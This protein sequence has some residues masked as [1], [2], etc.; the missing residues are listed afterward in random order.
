MFCAL[1]DKEVY[2]DGR[3]GIEI[4]VNQMSNI[5]AIGCNIYLGYGSSMSHGVTMFWHCPNLEIEAYG[6]LLPSEYNLSQM[7]PKCT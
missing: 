4:P 3:E 1:Y 7:L 6:K 2:R 5:G